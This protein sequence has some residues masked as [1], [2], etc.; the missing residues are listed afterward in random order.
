M[1]WA[2][3][4]EEPPEMDRLA[5]AVRDAASVSEVAPPERRFVT[6]VTMVRARRPRRI[7]QEALVVAWDTAS[8][9]DREGFGKDL[10]KDPFRNLSVPEVTVFTSTLTRSGPL[11]ETWGRVPLGRA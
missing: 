4:T 3:P 5:Q 1:L 10:G 7:D 6:H 9:E 2:V 11:Y 8:P